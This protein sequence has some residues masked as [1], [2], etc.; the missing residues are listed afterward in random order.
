MTEYVEKVKSIF[1]VDCCIESIQ[2]GKKRFTKYS[3][4]KFE[5]YC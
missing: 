4:E 5:K 2:I 3:A 1:F